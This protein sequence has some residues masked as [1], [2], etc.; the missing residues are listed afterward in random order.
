MR[1]LGLPVR[2]G[3]DAANAADE[4]HVKAE[5]FAE[6]VG[7]VPVDIG[8]AV[9]LAKS[10]DG[11]E[12]FGKDEANFLTLHLDTDIEFGTTYFG[13]QTMP[14]LLRAAFYVY[15]SSPLASLDGVSAPVLSKITAEP[16]DLSAPLR[17]PG[18]TAARSAKTASR[19]KAFAPVPERTVSEQGVTVSGLVTEKKDNWLMVRADGEE[20]PVKYVIPTDPGT[21]MLLDLQSIFTVN[22]VRIVYEAKDD[23]RQLVRIKKVVLKTVGTVTGEV[24]QNYDW[25][26]A[27]KP[28]EGPPQGYA[29]WY[30]P[31]TYDEI[32][33]ELKTLKI[34]DVVTIKFSTDS[35]RHH[36][37]VLEKRENK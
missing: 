24:L 18:S 29:L 4:P 35:E 34:G 2:A 14:S 3:R 5:F 6:G 22:R 7:W 10:G 17:M 15:S 26:V 1:P 13:R 19:P 31:G 37:E 36:I 33:K 28:K 30:K 27:V 12:Y 8:S 9:V 16:V 25:W 20:D 23:S 21:R 32:A 11:L